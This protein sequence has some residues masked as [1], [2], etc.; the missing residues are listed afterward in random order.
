[1]KFFL[2]LST[3]AT[4]AVAQSASQDPIDPPPNTVTGMEITRPTGP[5]NA[6]PQGGSGRQILPAT[7]NQVVDARANGVKCDGI[8]DDAPALQYLASQSTATAPAIVQL[9]SGTCN[10]ASPVLITKPIT[11]RGQGW[12]ENGP[13][14]Y[15][16][17]LAVAGTGFIP[18]EITGTVVRGSVMSFEDLAVSQLHPAP[19]AG[20]VPIDYPYV[21]YVHDTG[22]TVDFDHVFLYAINKGI[23]SYNV[24]RLHITNLYG[25]VFSNVLKTDH[26]MDIDRYV[27]FH[28]WP[29]WSSDASVIK[30]QQDNMDAIWLLRDDSPY[31]DRI[32]IYAARSGIRFSQGASGPAS[33]VAA[34][35]LTFDGVRWGLWLTDAV[36]LMTTQIGNMTWQGG[37]GIAPTAPI[38]GASA[39]QADAGTWG[40]LQLG[41]LEAQFGDRNI[42]TLASTTSRTILTIDSLYAASFRGGPNRTWLYAASVRNAPV[43]EISIATLPALAPTASSLLIN[44]DTN[45]ILRSPGQDYAV[46]GGP[47][48]SGGSYGMTGVAPKII[49]VDPSYGVTYPTMTFTFPTQPYDGME[50]QLTAE[51]FSVSRATFSGGKT[52]LAP[53]NIPLGATVRFKWNLNGSGIGAWLR[54]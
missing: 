16:T 26:T 43:H 51:N 42:V 36:N 10:I 7:G 24:G 27:D 15:G 2:M 39:I 44:H 54:V 46:I 37:A 32:F 33:K 17:Y 19:A 20:W 52:V 47:F 41:N 1:M 35:S 45:A 28:I 18:F 23:S 25:Q 9:P 22:G 30:Y 53:S 31:L 8:T 29:F 11:L 6:R 49:M 21:F 3:F 12:S 34:G 38:P 14:H 13:G 4:L 40:V 50:V 48:T 5:A